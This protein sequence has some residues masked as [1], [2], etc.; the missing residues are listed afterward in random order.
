M[1]SIL[2]ALLFATP[3]LMHQA[4][5]ESAYDTAGAFIELYGR[6]QNTLPRMYL[7]GVYDGF[8]MSNAMLS[9]SQEKKF[10]CLPESVGLI[11]PQLVAMMRGYLKK[12]PAGRPPS[13]S[14]RAPI[15]SRRSLSV[16]LKPLCL[17]DRSRSSPQGIDDLR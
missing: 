11:D 9:K 3:A 13:A 2:V 10:Y 17:G 6:G 7:R 8:G 4:K 14:N 1:R 16:Q 5:A 15:D 12:H